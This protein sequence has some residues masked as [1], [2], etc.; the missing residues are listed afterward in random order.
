MILATSE[1]SMGSGLEI[2]LSINSLL[3]R[4]PLTFKPFYLFRRGCQTKIWQDFSSNG[5]VSMASL[6]SIFLLHSLY[7]KVAWSLPAL[8]VSFIN[9][10]QFGQL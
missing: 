7:K 8:I 6:K 2:S 3:F 4:N 9:N 1:K 10:R 5:R